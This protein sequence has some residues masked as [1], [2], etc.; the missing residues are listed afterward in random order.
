MAGS[1]RTHARVATFVRGALAALL[2][3][4]SLAMAGAAAAQITRVDW[5]ARLE[6][7]GIVGPL[8]FSGTLGEFDASDPDPQPLAPVIEAI[9]GGDVFVLNP[10]G[11]TTAGTFFQFTDSDPANLAGELVG[12]TLQFFA[13]LRGLSLS[14]P[15]GVVLS[16]G[17]PGGYCRFAPTCTTTM[18]FLFTVLDLDGDGV[19]DEDD[20]CVDVPNPDQEDFDVGDDDD[21]SLPGVQHYGDACDVDFDND[22]TTG[23]TDFFA[24]MRPCFGADVATRPECAVADL[25]GDGGVG[26]SDFFGHFRPALGSVP[27]PGVTE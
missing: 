9:V 20:N 4:S 25:D 26:P 1:V 18:T 5:E 12:Q 23:P 19:L 8:D 21:T 24:V 7:G 11:S 3:L 27:G 6:G 13:F 10:P 17:G 22:G 16:T 2:A 15:D 14:A